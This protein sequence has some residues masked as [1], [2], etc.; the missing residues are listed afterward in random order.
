MVV[1]RNWDSLWI[2]LSNWH[3]YDNNKFFKNIKWISFFKH[4]VESITWKSFLFL[5]FWTKELP[6]S[7]LYGCRV[8]TIWAIFRRELHQKWRSQYL[9]Q[10]PIWD[11]SIASG[12]STFYA[13]MPVHEILAK[14]DIIRFHLQIFWLGD[15]KCPL[16]S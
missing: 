7:L 6:P 8:P 16:Q 3:K 9:Y 13:T 15:H 4:W 10:A 11:A 2:S 12:G 5:S 14:T 1:R